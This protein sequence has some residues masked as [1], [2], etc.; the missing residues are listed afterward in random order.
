MHHIMTLEA[1]KVATQLQWTG[2]I[3]GIEEH[4][5]GVIHLITKQI[6]TQYK[7]LQHD[8]HLKDLW[9]LAFSKKVHC[10]AQGKPVVT[11]S[12]TTEWLHM[13]ELQL[14]IAHKR[15]TLIMSA[16][17]LE[18]TLSTTLTNSPPVPLTWSLQNS[19]GTVPSAPKVPASP[20][21]TSRTCTLKH[22]STGL[23]I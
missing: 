19:F 14:T 23:S 15:R 22:P 1:F 6:I 2:S 21:P 5:F 10:L 3:I 12:P 7:K 18:V 16:S 13:L 17:L 20:A 9:V 8:P 4:C 11:I